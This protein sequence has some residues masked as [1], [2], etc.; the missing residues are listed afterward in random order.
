MNTYSSIDEIVKD[1]LTMEDAEAVSKLAEKAILIISQDPGNA[2]THRLYLLSKDVERTIGRISANL[3]DPKYIMGVRFAF[4]LAARPFF[5]SS[6]AVIMGQEALYLCGALNKMIKARILINRR[7]GLDA[8]SELLSSHLTMFDWMK[9]D[10]LSFA[11]KNGRP[12]CRDIFGFFLATAHKAGYIGGLC[13]NHY[14]PEYLTRMFEVASKEG[15]ALGSRTPE[16]PSQRVI[17]RGGFASDPQALA[18]GMC[19]TEDLEQ[20]A[21]FADRQLG[22]LGNAYVLSTEIDPEDALARFEHEAE[23]VLPYNERRAFQI[24]QVDA[25]NL[26]Q[27]QSIEEMADAGR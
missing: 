12:K 4:E 19:W 21:W 23:V 26:D 16:T 24:V 10:L 8:A 18:A 2:S 5:E 1:K 9:L 17:Y 22:Q 14:G 25:Q 20:A 7:S 15:L 6:G 27:S 13:V 3:S 11:W